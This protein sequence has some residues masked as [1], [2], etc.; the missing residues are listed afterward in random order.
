MAVNSRFSRRITI[1]IKI[2]SAVPKTSKQSFS[3]NKGRR[4]EV[5]AFDISA[6]GVGVFSDY[7]LPPGL[8]IALVVDGK[9]FGLKDLMRIKAQVRHCSYTPQKKYK[10]GIMFIDLK[11]EY[12][13]ALSRFLKSSNS[14]KAPRLFLK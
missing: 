13:K 9:S 12:R 5:V 14:R 4:L 10:T 2:T 8:K 7:F 1:D 11:D 3:L 6:L